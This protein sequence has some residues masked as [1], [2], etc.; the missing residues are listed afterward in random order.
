MP[1]VK[2]IN[3]RS[4]AGINNCLDYVGN[5]EKT[6]Y[7][8]DQLN[9]TLEYAANEEKTTIASIMNDGDMSILVSGYKCSPDTANE[10]FAE[11]RAKYYGKTKEILAENK[12]ARMAYHWIQSFSNETYVD[13]R[14]AHKI[15]LELM[16]RLEHFQAVV[17]THMN[18]EH[19]HNHIVMNAYSANGQFKWKDN[20]EH[21]NLVRDISDEIS[22]KYNL[23]III[24]PSRNEGVSWFE[25]KKRKEG[26]SWKEQIRMDIEAT[27]KVSSTWDEFKQTMIAGGYKIRETANSV[28]YTVPGDDNMKVRGSTLG[29][30]YSK[31]KIM[32]KLSVK[33]ILPEEK[34]HY[35]SFQGNYS[36]EKI[37][38]K[39]YAFNGR[40]RTDLEM[41]L[42]IAI[43]IIK[44]LGDMFRDNKASKIYPTNPVYKNAQWKITQLTEAY[45]MLNKVDVGSLDELN[46]KIHDTGATLSHL[47][48]QES[49]LKENIGRTMEVYTAASLVND[50]TS[51]I[52]QIGISEEGLYIEDYDET[53]IR[54]NRAKVFPLT[55]D[56]RKDIYLL[57]SESSDYKLN[58]K[59]DQLSFEEGR[60]VIDFL[61]GK[62]KVL[63][64]VLITQEQ[65]EKKR[66]INKYNKIYEETKKGLKE[67]YG[68]E[69]L[70]EAQKNTVKT[71]IEENGLDLN[72][73]QLKKHD[74]MEL[75][76]Y[77]NSKNPFREK[78]S[79]K[80][81]AYILNAI[82]NNP[83]LKLNRSIDLVSTD[84]YLSIYKYISNKG[85]GRMP[86]IFK[87]SKVITK[88]LANKINELAEINNVTLDVNVDAL[89]T[90]IGNKL[91]NYLLNIGRVPECLE[92]KTQEKANDTMF[93]STILDY[94]V[95]FQ[96]KIIEYR[97][98]MDYLKKLGYTKENAG[99]IIKYVEEQQEAYDLA[100]KEREQSSKEY[101]DLLRLRYLCE[102]SVNKQFTHGAL[103][104]EEIGIVESQEKDN[105]DIENRSNDIGKGSYF[106]SNDDYFE[107]LNQL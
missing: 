20:M 77:Y 41:L 12:K 37:Y 1:I 43:Q 48:K 58:Y 104:K 14:L 17:N 97:A 49:D 31:K 56:M 78:L 73:E 83:A 29:L 35:V 98:S 60:A 64:D 100:G 36:N 25:W 15:G 24:G 9:N 30:D 42:L 103:F 55:A 92:A 44:K 107:K 79:Q 74:A 45:V 99:E 63:P 4:E 8:H 27:L 33:T 13:P 40:R 59:L 52:E 75:I 102:L 16:E 87:E 38:V 26:Q 7:Q 54:E 81:K 89:T 5:E 3:I 80:Q 28:T 66:L 22:K 39:R 70:S 2:V 76:T 23:P 62:T 93:Y 96:D 6:T 51:L 57:I 69:E 85:K 91:Y 105:E 21:I 65:Y 53:A 18:T 50:M 61:K 46:Q 71:I 86:S 101:K 11:A 95:K 19:V 68:Q 32:E 10:E 84:D 47:K 88:S 34:Y 82:N 72:I 90:D 106:S 67:K 94:D